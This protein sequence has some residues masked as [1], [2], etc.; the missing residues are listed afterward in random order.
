[1]T[2]Q[3]VVVGATGLV[4]SE[5]VRKLLED[6]SYERVVTL[7]RKKLALHDDRLEQVIVDFEQLDTVQSYLEGA[8]V[9]CLLGTTIKTAGSQDAFRKVD[10]N[11]PL[12]LAQVAHAAGA[13]AFLIVTAMGA[14]AKSRVFYSRVKGELEK[15]LVNIPFARLHILRPS[16]LLGE[17]SEFRLGERFAAALAPLMRL[18]MVGRLKKFKPIHAKTIAKSMVAMSLEQTKGTFI[19]ESHEIEHAVQSAS[20]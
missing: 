6:G 7:A 9:F 4:G 18:F 20:L 16:L 17:R 5:V 2:K 1:M 13:H 12:K 11:Y 15:E 3:A 19:Y 10:Y 8:A 14:N